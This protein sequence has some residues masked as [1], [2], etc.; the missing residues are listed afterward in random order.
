MTANIDELRAEL[1]SQIFQTWNVRLPV[2]FIQ[3]PH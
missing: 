3:P 2:P 1:A